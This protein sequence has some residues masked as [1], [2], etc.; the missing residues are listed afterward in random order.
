MSPLQGYD[1]YLK[2]AIESVWGDGTSPSISVPILG[3]SLKPDVD[4]MD[5]GGEL[6]ASRFAPTPLAGRQWTPGGVHLSA[7]P[8]I[9]GYFLLAMYGTASAS[10][11]EPGVYD[12]VFEPGLTVD[13]SLSLECSK[14]GANP[15]MV[16][17]YMINKLAWNQGKDSAAQLLKLDIDGGGKFAT[18]GSPSAFAYPTTYPLSFKEAV[19]SVDGPTAYLE[20]IQWSETNGLVIPNHKISGGIETRQPVLSGAFK[21][22]G[23]FVL[24]FED[25]SNWDKFRQADDVAIS[26]VYTSTQIISGAQVYTL[27]ATIPKVRFKNPIP[28]INSRELVKETIGFDMFAG[29]VGGSTVPISYTLRCGTDFSAL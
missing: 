11:V 23:S 9:I 13:K 8:D 17:G 26:I 19:M 3:E 18:E 10:Q 20:S 22:E 14:G 15:L 28:D 12:N 2:F 29:T 24:D 16:P 1:S 25:L 4:M 27:T 21:G 7:Y 5:R 6:N